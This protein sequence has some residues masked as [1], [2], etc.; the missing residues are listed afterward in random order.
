MIVIVIEFPVIDPSAARV[1][2][3]KYD[4]PVCQGLTLRGKVITVKF[5]GAQKVTGKK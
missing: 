2:V 3:N 4:R 5:N 1:D